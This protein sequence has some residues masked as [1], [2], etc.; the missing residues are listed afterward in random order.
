[1][2]QL[3][4]M[5]GGFI[6]YAPRLPDDWGMEEA[7]A[8]TIA[9]IEQDILENF[10]SGAPL[11]H[12]AYCNTAYWLLGRVV[13]HASGLPYEVLVAERLF[14]S[15]GMLDSGFS[16]IDEAVSPHGFP[17]FH[18]DGVNVNDPNKALLTHPT[19]PRKPSTKQ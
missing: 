8:T 16:G 1:M 9:E 2:G 19:H 12:A 11:A 4:G 3:V 7:L 10:W 15:A 14:A 13:E 18:F 6:Q 17:A 5:M